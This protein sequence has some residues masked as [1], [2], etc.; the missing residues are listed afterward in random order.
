MHSPLSNL[1]KFNTHHYERVKKP[2]GDEEAT[3]KLAVL[4]IYYHF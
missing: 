4:E 1:K 3:K 2:T